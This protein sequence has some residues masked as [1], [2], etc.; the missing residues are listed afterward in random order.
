MGASSFKIGTRDSDRL[1]VYN[2]PTA[3][4]STTSIVMRMS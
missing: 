1:K 2:F 3:H 4:L